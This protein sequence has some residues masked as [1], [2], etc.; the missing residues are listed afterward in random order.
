MKANIFFTVLALVYIIFTFL[1]LNEL[2]K[3]SDQ[4]VIN[5]EHR[6]EKE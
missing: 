5:S 4:P 1:F 3:R 6:K 2:E